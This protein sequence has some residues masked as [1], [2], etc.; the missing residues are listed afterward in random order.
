[1]NILL[2]FISLLLV[3]LILG[4]ALK[5]L[6]IMFPKIF[7]EDDFFSSKIINGQI[8]VFLISTLIK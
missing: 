1:M 4:L 3:G 5:L 2:G 7:S 8:I 6:N